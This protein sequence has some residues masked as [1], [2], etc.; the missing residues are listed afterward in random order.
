MNPPFVS[1][2]GIYFC[3]VAEAVSTSRRA[4]SVFS[5]VDSQSQWIISTSFCS[6]FHQR[7]NGFFNS[8]SVW[9][10]STFTAKRSKNTWKW[11][12]NSPK[13]SEVSSFHCHHYKICASFYYYSSFGVLYC[14][15]WCFGF[16]NNMPSIYL[17]SSVFSCLKS[18]LGITFSWRLSFLSN[19]LN[20]N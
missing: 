17:H 12:Y 4:V 7:R 13:W 8:R 6:F 2:A 20:S 1:A 15:L 3:N 18:P 11:V 16:L 9:K 14:L 19:I 5:P 10:A